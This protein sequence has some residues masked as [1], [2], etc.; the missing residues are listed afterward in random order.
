MSFVRAAVLASVV[1]G[2]G[3]CMTKA[4]AVKFAYEADRFMVDEQS[5]GAD[6]HDVIELASANYNKPPD[7][8][9]EK[10]SI[11]SLKKSTLQEV[12]VFSPLQ[13]I[14]FAEQKVIEVRYKFI[15]GRFEQFDIELEE[16]TVDSKDLLIHELT[17]SLNQNLE[18]EGAISRWSGKYDVAMLVRQGNYKF[19]MTNQLY[20]PKDHH[21]NKLTSRR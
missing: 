10:T 12:C 1:I 14:R 11:A 3:G 18:V 5:L 9:V 4:F 20:R 8:I 15:N 13:S 17:T 19:H 6:R 21:Y 7:C 16:L 2:L